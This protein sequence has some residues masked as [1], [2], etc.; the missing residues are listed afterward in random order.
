MFHLKLYPLSGQIIPVAR[1]NLHSN[2]L[3]DPIGI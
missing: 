3:Q 2:L 1:R